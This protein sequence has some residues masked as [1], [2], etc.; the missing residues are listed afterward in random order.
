MWFSRLSNLFRGGVL[1]A[2]LLATAWAHAQALRWVPEFRFPGTFFPAYAIS[3][4]GRDS[5]GPTDTASAYGFLNSGSFGVKVSDAPAGARLK[6]QVEVPE[7]G[8]AGEIETVA[9]TDGKPR[10]L[11]PRL[12][13][14]Q[15]RLASI[16][17]P[18]STDAV[19]RMFVDG[20]LVGEER[21]PVRVRAANDA[22]L[23]VCKAPD[24]CTDYGVFMAAFVNENHPAIDGILRAALDIPAM[25]LKAWTGTQ[26][27]AED[28]L[29]QV[30]AIWY[31]FQ[32]NKVTYSSI[33]T[34][35]DTRADLYSQTVRPLG[36]TLR[37]AQANCIDGTAVFASVLRKIGI[38]PLIVL[39]PGHAFLGFFT[40]SQQT[41]PVFLETTMLN[42]ASN[43]FHQQGP[44]KAG[45]A[46][47]KM[48]G[49]DNRMNQ[50]WQSF[51]AAL[52][53][54]QQTY[55]KAMPYFGKQPGFMVV[56]VVKARASGILPLP[57]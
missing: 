31:L 24:Q 1:A 27:S 6:V 30:W 34:V 19:F 25:P 42:D 9:S 18:L 44:T 2:G 40:D 41:Q 20:T 8:V 43:P 29:K 11:V 35:S 49:T 47:A 21:R 22:P 5:K 36:Q 52:N 23:R 16:A 10:S 4:A 12:S 28:V 54:G 46:L 3:A 7:I 38:E 56:P 32:R 53:A 33:T 45:T 13:W 57:L 14:S 51:Q 17:Q 15:A 48:L 26:G 39:V 50:S 37:T 55:A